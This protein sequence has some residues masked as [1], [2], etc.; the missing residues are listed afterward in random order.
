MVPIIL[1]RLAPVIMAS[2]SLTAL[3]AMSAHA[4]QADVNK[5]PPHDLTRPHPAV[6][7]PPAAIVSVPAPADA[8]VLFGGRDLSAWQADDGSAA[9]WTI[10]N[11]WFEVAPGKGGVRTKQSF[12]DVQLHVEWASPAHREGEGQEPGNSG[13]FLMGMYEVQVLDSYEGNI[14]YADGQAGAL[15]GQY[16]PLV[17]VSRAPGEWQS[18]DIIFHRPRFDAAGKVTSPATFTVLHNGVLIQDHSALVGPTAHQARPPYKAHADKLPISLQD[19]GQ[20][21]RYRNI[22]LRSLER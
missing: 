22:W 2:A 12:G 19:H 11:G 17:N 10:G 21:V 3:G 18:Y 16:P 7:A 6:V 5:W 15:Y 8:I 9:P 14:T 20:P 1:R 4:Q 13:V